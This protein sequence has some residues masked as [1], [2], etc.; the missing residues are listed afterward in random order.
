MATARGEFRDRETHHQETD[1]RFH[2]GPVTDG[3]LLV[4]TRQKEVEPKRREDASHKSGESIAPDRHGHY[5]RDQDESR[6][7][8][9][10]RRAKRYKR[11]RHGE[12]CRDG[13]REHHP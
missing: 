1:C 5:D 12:G 4:R 3:Q 11:R 13:E 8:V 10:K 7:R 2:V 6:A 9:G